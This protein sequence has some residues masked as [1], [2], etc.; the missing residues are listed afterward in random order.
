MFAGAAC[1]FRDIKQPEV[2]RIGY[3]APPTRCQPVEIDPGTAFRKTA[4][5]ALRDTCGTRYRAPREVFGVHHHR[6]LVARWRVDHFLTRYLFPYRGIA[7]L[8][9][10]AGTGF[11]P[12][13]AIDKVAFT[14]EYLTAQTIMRDA[15]DTLK[16]I[17]FELGGKSLS[18]SA[19]SKKPLLK[20][21]VAAV[22]LLCIPPIFHVWSSVRV[23][24]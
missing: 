18:S 23:Y 21:A 17:T 22:A 9:A 11:A 16:R 7:V 3:G 2:G 8:I 19:G 4:D 15:A 13:Y 14:G 12:E 10:F 20:A 1:S 6:L 24:Y 5:F